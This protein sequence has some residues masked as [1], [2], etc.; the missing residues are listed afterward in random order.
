MTAPAQRSKESRDA[1][2]SCAVETQFFR[3]LNRLVEPHVRAGWGSPRFVPGGVIV[4]ETRSRRTGKRLRIPLAAIRIQGHVVVSTFRGDRSEWVKNL[5]A[6][7][8][9]RYWLRGRAHDTTALVI[10]PWRRRASAR[11]RAGRGALVRALARAVHLRGLGVRRPRP[12]R[13]KVLTSFPSVHES[14]ISDQVFARPMNR[15]SAVST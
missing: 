4:L 6:N 5:A 1:T 2:R 12:R 10:S 9:A 8:A 14:P 13:G 7:P 3:M 15:P 11:R